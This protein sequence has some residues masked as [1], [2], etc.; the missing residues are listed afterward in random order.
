MTENTP[1]LTEAAR[2]LKW[3]L[4]LTQIGLFA[5]RATRAEDDGV[6]DRRCG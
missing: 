1:H 3:P 6:V 4:R 2:R 5:E